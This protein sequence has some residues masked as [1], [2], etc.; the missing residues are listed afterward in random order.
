M[1]GPGESLGESA[2]VNEV[3]RTAGPF[4]PM[5]PSSVELRSPNASSTPSGLPHTAMPLCRRGSHLA[6]FSPNPRGSGGS[7]V[8]DRVPLV[9]LAAP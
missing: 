2:L 6:Y 8:L 1:L 3:P 7:A 4:G 5:A 9:T